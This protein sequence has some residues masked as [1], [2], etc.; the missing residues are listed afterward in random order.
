MEINL[1]DVH[2][3]WM[4]TNGPVQIKTIATHY[5]VY[6]DLFGRAYFLP[7]VPFKVKV[8]AFSFLNSFWRNI[9]KPRSFCICLQYKISEEE[10]APVCYGNVLKPHQTKTEP[11]VSFDPRCNLIGRE[12][13][14]AH[15]TP[16]NN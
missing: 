1:N 12:V 2:K 4:A 16:N 15:K 11:E 14:L 7:R 5:G 8:R 3:E 10:Y 9:S 6:Q 13:R